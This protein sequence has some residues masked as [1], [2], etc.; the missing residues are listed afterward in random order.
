MAKRIHLGVVLV[1]GA[2]AVWIAE[3][4]VAQKAPASNP[5]PCSVVPQPEPCGAKPG[6]AGKSAAEQFPFPGET[7]D[8]GTPD[9]PAAKPGAPDIGGVPQAPGVS[10]TPSTPAPAAKPDTAKEFPFPGEDSTPNANGRT[11]GGSSSSS[12]SG[13][14]AVPVDPGGDNSPLKDKGSEGSKATPGRHILHRVN[15][16]GTKLQTPDE[17][18]AEDLD[19]AHFYV[20]S[21]DLQGAYLRGKDAVK[22]APNDA[23]AH[24]ALAEIALKLNKRDEAIAE[25][26]ACLKLDASEKQV[27]E[28]RKALARLKP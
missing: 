28:S 25:Y 16:V 22:T 5:A 14:D 4:G 9:A 23:D 10:G 6:A 7:N 20:Q 12:S 2:L 21:G 3:P 19:I 11:G 8:K 26:S 15:P 17:R 13:D 24:F 18:E 1:A 27:K